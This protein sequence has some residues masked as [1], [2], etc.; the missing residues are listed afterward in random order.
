MTFIDGHRNRHLHGGFRSLLTIALFVPAHRADGLADCN[1]IEDAQPVRIRGQSAEDTLDG[2]KR[3]LLS[4]P[5]LLV[6]VMDHGFAAIAVFIFFLDHRLTFS[7]PL[8]LLDHSTIAI[9]VMIVSFSDRHAG[10]N[11]A[12]MYS[13]L[14]REGWRSQSS[15]QRESNNIF[16]HFLLP[17]FNEEEKPACDN[18]FREHLVKC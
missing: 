4:G 11:R 17:V 1:K 6:V 12:G 5:F 3:R 7:R 16:P 10:S 8:S 13:N 15:G 14:V 2:I 18:S 9:A